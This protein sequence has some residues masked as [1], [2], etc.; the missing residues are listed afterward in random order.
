MLNRGETALARTG[1]SV[2]VP[3]VAS[4]S[5]AH[6]GGSE[7]VTSDH[8]KYTMPDLRQMWR[9]PQ[10]FEATVDFYE[11]LSSCTS[12]LMQLPAERRE[13]VLQHRLKE[14]NQKLLCSP[15]MQVRCAIYERR[16]DSVVH[17]TVRGRCALLHQFS[18]T[19]L[20]LIDS[21]HCARDYS[22]Y[23]KKALVMS[24]WTSWC[25]ATGDD[26]VGTPVLLCTRE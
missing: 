4:L 25:G 15:C 22:M 5:D 11:K 17:D 12:G 7:I 23:H 3:T 21:S 20:E 6:A 16:S 24:L 10:I 8:G 13:N 14:C 26:R 19:L 2:K 1:G 18:A 9:A